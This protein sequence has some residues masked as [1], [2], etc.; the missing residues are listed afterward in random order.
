MTGTFVRLAFAAV[1]LGFCGS[2]IASAAQRT[3]KVGILSDMSG[4]YSDNTGTDL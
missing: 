4:P 3:I 1:A 2:S